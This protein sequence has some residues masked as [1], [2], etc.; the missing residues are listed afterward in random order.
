METERTDEMSHGTYLERCL[1]HGNSFI[2]DAV[3]STKGTVDRKVMRTY[4][5]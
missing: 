4:G 3:Y 5:I 2:N 1:A